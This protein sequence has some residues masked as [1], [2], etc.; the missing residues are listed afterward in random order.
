MSA[1]ADR[2]PATASAAARLRLG[3]ALT[4]CCAFAYAT[5][6]SLAR[7]AYDGGAD[8]MTVT[9]FRAGSAALLYVTACLARH[10]PLMPP[11]GLRLPAAAVGLVWLIGAY[12]YVTSIRLIPIGLAVTIFYLFPLIVA[13]VARVAEG[14]RLSPAR[15]LAL[16]LGFAGV[17]LAVGVSI[18]TIAPLGIGLALVAAIGLSINITV[19]A[20]VMRR[21]SPLTAMAAM[22]GT[23]ALALLVVAPAVG[24]ALPA[25]PMGWFGVVAGAGVF[26]FANTLFYFA[27]SLIGS[28]RAAMICNIEPVAATFFAYLILGEA[29]G[30]L[31]L[32]GVALVIGAILLMQTGERAQR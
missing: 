17:A 8:P 20:R 5:L 23:A 18:G 32:A 24:M 9:V 16:A 11:R 12:C 26:C 19:N 14:E 30:P 13:L 25:T 2:L 10:L 15:L 6:P 31:Q 28:V 4:F 1:S 22:T 29:L 7:L 27:I 21:A 3:F